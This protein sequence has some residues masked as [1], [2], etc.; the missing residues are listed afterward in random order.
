MQD[1]IKLRDRNSPSPASSTPASSSHATPKSSRSQKQKRP[2]S[3]SSAKS[4]GAKKAKF[5]KNQNQTKI[6][7][8]FFKPSS[9]PVPAQSIE[10]EDAEET[11]S[12]VP[13]FSG[14]NGFGGISIARNIF[15][16]SLNSDAE[17]GSVVIADLMDEMI[18]SVEDMMSQE[19]ENSQVSQ[20]QSHYPG[21]LLDN[22]NS[23]NQ[24]NSD[25]LDSGVSSTFNI[26]DMFM[27]EQ[28]EKA[29]K[30]KAQEEEDRKVA[31]NLDKILNV[32]Q[33]TEREAY[34][35]REKRSRP[36]KFNDSK[37]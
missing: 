24:L 3:S 5:V 16:H 20:S 7:K 4:S 32:Y 36:V 10:D 13:S 35:I 15:E 28:M 37:R 30:R 11:R 21:L 34:P 33:L 6:S 18:N 17:D 25:N 14:R 31:E 22:A 29:R 12:S 2:S 27:E 19:I 8:Y 1:S 9:V 23:Q 26:Y